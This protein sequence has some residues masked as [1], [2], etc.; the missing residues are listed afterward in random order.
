MSL[1]ALSTQ[2]NRLSYYTELIATT[3]QPHVNP[4]LFRNFSVF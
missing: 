2:Y 1:L 4:H 3:S